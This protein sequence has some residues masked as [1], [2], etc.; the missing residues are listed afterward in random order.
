MMSEGDA[1]SCPAV[2]AEFGE[3]E[4]MSEWKEYKFKDF[5]L[6]DLRNG[7]NKPSKVRG[8]GLR[9]INMKEIFKY[10]KISDITPMELV[11]VTNKE[12]DGCLLEYNDL[13]FARQSLV[14]SGAGKISIFKGYFPTVFES[15][16]IRCRVNQEKASPDF[17][18]YLFKSPL[19]KGTVSTIVQQVAAAGIRG[20]DLQNLEFSIP[21]SPNKRRSHL[22][23]AAST[24]KSTCC[25]ARIRR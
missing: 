12:L 10:D 11:P 24:T 17:I 15:H 18:Y 9:M 3:G 5:F 16:L 4:G 1:A 19:G 25:T 7:L 13:L 21:L 6:I 23:S 14:E 22:S 2:R 8:S 20:S